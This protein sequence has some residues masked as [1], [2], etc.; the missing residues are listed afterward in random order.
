MIGLA[1]FIILLALGYGFGSILEKK[2]FKYII[3]REDEL[4]A[5]LVIASKKLPLEYQNA[6]FHN[7]FVD[8]SVVISIDYFKNFVAGLRRLVGGRIRTYETLLERARREALLRMKVQAEN[9]GA[10][11]VFNCKLETASISKGGE[12]IIGAVEVY[13]YGTAII[14]KSG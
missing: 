11:A 4:K 8:G 7:E 9:H 6:T 12:G 13:A 14:P 1:T 2:H 3:K 10:V 5:V